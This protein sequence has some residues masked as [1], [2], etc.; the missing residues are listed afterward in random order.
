M[1]FFFLQVVAKGCWLSPSEK[2]HKKDAASGNCFVGTPIFL[3]TV[4]KYT[5]ETVVKLQKLMQ[6]RSES[7][8]FWNMSFAVVMTNI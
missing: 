7:C 1:I 3:Q 6:T 8:T 2:H 5:L 4:P